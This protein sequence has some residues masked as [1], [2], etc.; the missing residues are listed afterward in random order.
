[1]H[2]EVRL[3]RCCQL[4]KPHH[5]DTM[6][7]DPLFQYWTPEA[8]AECLSVSDETYRA[9]WH[10]V[11]TEPPREVCETPDAWWSRYSLSRYWDKLTPEE[12]ADC[13]RAALHPTLLTS[14]K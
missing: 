4:P 2:S 1:M 13:N 8:V 5:G 6:K 12:Q 10:I 11:A 14:M 7:P 3:A 9:L